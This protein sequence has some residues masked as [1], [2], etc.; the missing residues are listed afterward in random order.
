MLFKL[1]ANINYI[2]YF[3]CIAFVLLILTYI[4]YKMFILEADIYI[5]LE[6]INKIELEFNTNSKSS[7]CSSH[8]KNNCSM[9]LSDIIMNEVFNPYPSILKT[10]DTIND[11]KDKNN[12]DVIDI[13]DII[14]DIK[15]K[16]EEPDNKIIFDLKKDVSVVN[17]N[18]SVVS[19]NNQITK[20][21]LQKLNL[22]KLK[23]KCT[24]LELSTEGSKAQ[25][26]E[27]ILEE[28][29]KEV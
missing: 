3:I 22:D 9:K 10:N 12:I 16:E 2:F 17:D 15:E 7:S 11:D 29:N 28:L 21:K 1:L 4:I 8:N 25:L 23:D 18:E 26:I 5:L 24:E 27:R 6:K 19:S 20:K 13:D 14:A